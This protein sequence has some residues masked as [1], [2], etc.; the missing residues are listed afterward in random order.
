MSRKSAILAI[1]LLVPAPS[2]GVLCAMVL[3]PGSPLGAILFGLSKVWLLS[4]PVVWILLVDRTPFS[5]SP[6][7]NGGLAAGLL[8]GVGISLAILVVY[9]AA[10]RAL[11]DRE[12][13]VAKLGA[14]GLGSRGAYFAAAGFW[15]LVN[16]V[17]EEY[18]WRWFCVRQ[19]ERLMSPVAAVLLS[20]LFFTLHHYVALRVYLGGAAVL[21][22]AAG[23]FIGG[24]IWSAMYLKYRSIW[25]G[26]LSHAIV[27][28]CIFGI[29]AALLF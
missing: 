28:V 14:V 17:L 22:C 7:R 8:T 4:L 27:D 26:Y 3:F 6:V 13:L 23:V 21:V 5:L 1:A 24:T 15:I 12:L 11:V 25:P 19:C 10:G 9:F 16:S 29:G 2:L 20:A 18:V